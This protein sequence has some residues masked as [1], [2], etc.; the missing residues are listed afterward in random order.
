MSVPSSNTQNMTATTIGQLMQEKMANSVI[1]QSILDPYRTYPGPQHIANIQ[2]V[3]AENGTLVVAN[4][5][6]FVVA[7]GDS[8][9]DVIKLALVSVQLEK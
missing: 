2:I 9:I 7:G 4:G 3:K 6:T 1:G 5:K 8:V